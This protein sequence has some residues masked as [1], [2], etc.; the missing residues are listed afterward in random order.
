MKENSFQ[1]H[2]LATVAEQLR[3]DPMSWNNISL[4]YFRLP[5][6]GA[7]VSIE[8]ILNSFPDALTLKGSKNDCLILGAKHPDRLPAELA[9][10]FW[11]ENIAEES[12]AAC[13]IV[14]SMVTLHTA[15]ETT[16]PH[17]KISILVVEDDPATSKLV[18]HHLQQ[19]GSVTTTRNAREATANNTV[20]NP[21]IILLDIHYKDDAYDGFDVLANIL[22]ARPDAFVVM[23]SGDGNP[24]TVLRAP[25]LGAQGFIAKPFN[26]AGFS[27]Y[28][29]KFTR[30]A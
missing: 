10:H 6:G 1:T 18:A 2:S 17:Q 29:A 24:A 3:R 27:H 26:A 12:S 22:S 5:A 14:A 13:G 25:S 16:K 11:I 8:D 28:L 21:D 15:P 19:F 20:G 23:F 9:A 30:R 7:S 4:A